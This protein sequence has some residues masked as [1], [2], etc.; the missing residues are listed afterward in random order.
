MLVLA[1][2]EVEDHHSQE[3]MAD[4]E[5]E[6]DTLPPVELLVLDLSDKVIM[7]V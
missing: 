3:V 7:E 5:E 2:D 1:E 6:E 4:Q